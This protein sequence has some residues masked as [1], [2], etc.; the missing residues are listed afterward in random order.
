ME[1]LQ[2]SVHTEKIKS[3]GMLQVPLEED[4]NVSDTKPDVARIIYSSGDIKLDEIKTGMNKIWVKGQ[5]C[6]QILY[7]AEGGHGGW[8]SLYGGDLSGKNRGAG[9]GN[10]QGGL[11]RYAG[12]YD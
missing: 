4:I 3:K 2:K 7:Q 1:L 11:G 10:L 12:T 8:T 5:L 9:Q 6:Y